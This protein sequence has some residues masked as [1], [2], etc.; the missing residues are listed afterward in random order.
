MARGKV[1]EGQGGMKYWR[2]RVARGQVLA[3][4]GLSRLSVACRTIP[5]DRQTFG[6]LEGK[7]YN[8]QT[9]KDTPMAS[10]VDP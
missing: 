8:R 10:V 2:D 5:R 4:L 6:L 1:R 9:E 3:C 7:L